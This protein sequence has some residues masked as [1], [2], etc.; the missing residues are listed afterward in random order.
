MFLVFCALIRW[1]PWHARM[2]VPMLILGA[3]VVAI[4]AQRLVSERVVLTACFVLILIAQP[5]IFWN[6]D[7]PFIGPSSIFRHERAS[8]YF[9]DFAGSADGYLEAVGAVSR[10]GCT[11]VGIDNSFDRT[12]PPPR[13]PLPE[14]AVM[15]VLRASRPETRFI[16]VGVRNASERFS[17]GTAFSTPCAIICLACAGDSPKIDQFRAFGRP[18]IYGKAAVFLPPRAPEAGL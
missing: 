8:E 2:H 12:A 13:E 6:F 3:P 5:Y 14:Y 16:H 1:Q 17:G 4:L 10:S 7:H 18:A 11:R 15:A 9:S